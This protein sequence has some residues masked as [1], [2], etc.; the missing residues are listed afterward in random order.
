DHGFYPDWSPDGRSLS[1]GNS[2][3]DGSVWVMPADSG[4]PRLAADSVGQTAMTGNGVR[5]SR[6]GRS[7][8]TRSEAGSS[9]AYWSIPLDGSPP[10]RLVSF[11]PDGPVP[12]RG[13]WGAAAGRM[14]YSASEQRSDVW[15]METERP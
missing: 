10:R 13:G 15:V 4:P 7:L 8:Y 12:T 11:D 3:I 1:F 14:V 2:L 5:W 9:M 6:D